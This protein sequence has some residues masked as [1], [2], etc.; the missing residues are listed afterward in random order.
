MDTGESVQ[1]P[2]CQGCVQTINNPETVTGQGKNTDPTREEERGHVP[3]T[4]NQS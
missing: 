4:E 3:V 2:R 1:N